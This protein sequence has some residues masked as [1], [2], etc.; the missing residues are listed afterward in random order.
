MNQEDT[1]KALEHLQSFT[2]SEDTVEELVEY[3]P[4]D[5]E[6][7]FRMVAPVCYE[8]ITE[9]WTIGRPWSARIG[10]E[11]EWTD[12]VLTT[13]GVAHEHP[14]G[15]KRSFEGAKNRI[16]GNLEE[17]LEEFERQQERHEELIESLEENLSE[18]DEGESDEV[19]HHF[20]IP[21]NLS[22]TSEVTASYEPRDEEEYEDVLDEFQA[23]IDLDDDSYG[24]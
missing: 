20:V 14:Y 22:Y 3:S 1:E 23:L 11:M 12:D 5:E 10:E 19:N 24:W 18:E 15:I 7:S 6:G 2:I 9:E 16:R 13:M 21:S 4:P 8:P 17:D